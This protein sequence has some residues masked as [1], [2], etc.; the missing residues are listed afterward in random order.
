M[1]KMLYRKLMNAVLT[2]LILVYLIL[3]ELIW[4]RIAEPIY[5]FIH[6]LKILQSA[7]TA[8]AGLNRYTLLVVFLIL[9]AAV[10]GLGVVA[11]GMIAQG[12]IIPGTVIY[13]GKIPVAAFTFWLFKIAKGKLLTFMWFNL[14]YEG[15]LR[16]LDAIKHNPIY[17]AIKAKAATVK[18]WF[19]SLAIVAFAKKIKAALGFSKPGV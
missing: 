4:E 15:L 5:E 19:K 18:T 13:A 8:I 16:L 2:V 10:E 3:D 1:L 6:S 9:F 7:E 14:C 11:I 12:L 17:L